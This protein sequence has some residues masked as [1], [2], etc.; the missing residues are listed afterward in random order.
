MSNISKL[1]L[2]YIAAPMV[3]QSDLPFR[4][5][6]GRYGATMSYTQMYIPDKLLNDRDYLEYH[7]RDLSAGLEN[8]QKP[9]TVAQLC[10]NHSQTIVEAGKKL[11]AYCDGIGKALAVLEHEQLSSSSSQ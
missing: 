10:G 1:K 8:G 9:L 11:Q 2:R 5:L 4:L 6:V 3:N 7:I